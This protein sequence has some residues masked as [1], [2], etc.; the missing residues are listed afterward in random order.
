MTEDIR[1]AIIL[2]CSVLT[3]HNFLIDVKDAVTN[4]LNAEVVRERID[5]ELE[6]DTEENDA[7]N[8]DEDVTTRNALIRHMTYKM[9]LNDE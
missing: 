5:G 6:Q 9:K 4:T 3:L 2:T 8:V 1:L 7:E